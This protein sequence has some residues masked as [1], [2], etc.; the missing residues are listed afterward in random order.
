MGSFANSVHVKCDDANE[1]VA[2][3]ANAM[4]EGDLMRT[5]I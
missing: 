5:E 2:S 4:G 3:V 1:V